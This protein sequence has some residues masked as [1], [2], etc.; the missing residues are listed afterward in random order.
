MGL[1]M[2]LEGR[3]H[4]YGNENEDLVS[5]KIV[6]PYARVKETTFEFIAKDAKEIVFE[7]GYW[8]KANAIHKWFVDHC[9]C[10]AYDEYQGEDIDVSKEQ[11]KELQ[12]LC[13]KVLKLLQETTSLENKKSIINEFLP[14]Q[15]GFFFGYNDSEE[16][17]EWY[18][19]DLQDTIEIVDKA[20]EKMKKYDISYLYYNASW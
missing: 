17:I 16:G 7:F 20:L 5:I 9:W 6:K 19:K 18:V 11:L 4:L 10:E 15:D 2:F 14:M 1:D 3:K 12:E 13:K 8:R